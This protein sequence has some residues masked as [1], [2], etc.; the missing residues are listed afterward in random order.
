MFVHLKTAVNM[1]VYPQLN[2]FLQML[3]NINRVG[4]VS[5]ITNLLFYQGI[6]LRMKIIHSLM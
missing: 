4:G 3:P 6:F 2:K 5:P 1:S